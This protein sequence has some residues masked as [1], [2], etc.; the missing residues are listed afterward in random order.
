MTICI[1]SGN[2]KIG[3]TANISLP[4]GVACHCDAPC[5]K[6]GGCYADK[7]YR[8]YP[9]VRAAWNRNWRLWKKNKCRYFNAIYDWLY[10]K[11]PQY[12]RWHVSGDIPNQEYAQLMEW[13]ADGFPKTKFL[14]FTKKHDLIWRDVSNL[15]VYRS[16]WPQ[17]GDAGVTG[18]HA[19]MQ[20]GTETRVPKD[21]YV[22]PGK[23]EACRFCWKGSGD[24][25]FRKH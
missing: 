15:V 22:C 16:M 11:Q 24:V 8:M 18:P 7:A 10:A 9:G 6:S 5:R 25:V 2:M 20:D 3:K 1:S 13:I 14:V 19:W 21:A 23:C 4:P 17:W 12:F